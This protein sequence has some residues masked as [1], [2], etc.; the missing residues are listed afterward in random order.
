MADTSDP[1]ATARAAGQ[2]VASYWAEL[3]VACQ[4]EPVEVADKHGTVVAVMVSK[5]HWDRMMADDS[6]WPAPLD[7]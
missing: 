3:L 6:P 7:E 5:D 4:L 1:G 2:S